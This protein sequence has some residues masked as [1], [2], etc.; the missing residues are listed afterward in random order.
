VYTLVNK[1]DHTMEVV[2][3]NKWSI[4]TS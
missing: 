4:M 2:T 1:K 3:H